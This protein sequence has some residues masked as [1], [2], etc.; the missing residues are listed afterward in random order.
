MFKGHINGDDVRRLPLL[1]RKVRL[2]K[3]LAKQKTA[4]ISA[5]MSKVKARSYSNTPAS[6]GVRASSQNEK[7]CPMK[8]AGLDDG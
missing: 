1:D 2:R 5:T 4:F 3:I 7:T 6:S 8:A